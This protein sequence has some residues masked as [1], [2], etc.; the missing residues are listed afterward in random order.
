MTTTAAKMTYSA[1]LMDRSTG[2]IHSSTQT[3]TLAP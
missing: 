1:A 3:K 2:V